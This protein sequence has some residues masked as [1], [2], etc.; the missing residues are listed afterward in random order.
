MFITRIDNRKLAVLCDRV[1]VA[2]DVGQDPYRIFERESANG[3]SQYSRHLKSVSEKVKLGSSL[4]EA[5][6][7]QGNYFPQN[8]VR[9]V[10]V[11]EKTGRL[12]KVLD[13]LAAYYKDMS[14]LQ[15]E[16]MGSITWP[17]IQLLIGLIVISVLIVVP[18]LVSEDKSEMADLLG[19][20]LVGFPGLAIFWGWVGGI[21]A[22]VTTIWLLM[23]NGRLAFLSNWFKRLPILGRALL[24]FD[25]AAFVQAL[26]LSI[27]SGIDA[28]NAIGLSFRSTPSGV[29]RAKADAAQEAIRQG[30]DMH[31]VLQE[32]GLFCPETIEAVQLGESTGRLAETLD[33]H[34]QFLRM[35]VRFAMNTLT[36]L[37]STIVWLI[38][39]SILIMTIFRIF[40]RYLG[41]GEKAVERMFNPGGQSLE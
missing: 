4:T 41:A 11:G 23:R 13:R 3:D 7:A 24:A 39:A 5:V 30:R 28:W 32:T 6:K 19:I 18:A 17:L 27:E 37:A 14:D 15:D 21:L 25:E 31:T 9:L 2:F 40:S 35:K 38:V 20:G 33:K 1:G 16:F 29:Y 34:Y 26:G 10:E 22:V 36:H 12:E 8:F